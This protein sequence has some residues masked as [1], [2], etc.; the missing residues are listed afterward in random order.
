MSKQ[1]KQMEMDNLRDTF[2]DVRD[3]VVL[4]VNKQECNAAN[5]M[6]AALRKK[7]IRFKMVKNSLARRVFDD[8]GI[9]VERFWD[10][11]TVL[12]WGS[13]SVAD[14]SKELD[15]LLKKND[16]LKTKGA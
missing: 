16:K 8:M 1:I 15:A 10:G 2:R 4:S 12:A 5:Q 13:S 6:R 14:L 9:R 11:S 7:N 3:L